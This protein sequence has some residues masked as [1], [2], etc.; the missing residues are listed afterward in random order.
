MHAAGLP[1]GDA[2]GDQIETRAML[3]RTTCALVLCQVVTHA[4]AQ[5]KVHAGTPIKVVGKQFDMQRDASLLQVAQTGTERLQLAEKLLAEGADA[6]LTDSYGYTPLHWAAVNGH[7][8]MTELLL[9]KTNADIDARN[10]RDLTPLF[11][12]AQNG[13]V[14][15][16]RVLLTHG[17]NPTGGG[18]SETHRMFDADGPLQVASRNGHQNIVNLYAELKLGEPSVKLNRV[19]GPPTQ[20]H[21]CNDRYTSHCSECSDD[22]VGVNLIHSLCAWME[23]G[24]ETLCEQINRASQCRR[25][26]NDPFVRDP[27]LVEF[28]AL[29]ANSESIGHCLVS[30]PH[31]TDDLAV[32]SPS[33]ERHQ[34]L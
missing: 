27:L 16:A 3:G 4:A 1:R 26:L 12:A 10:D 8:K 2:V 17:A 20:Y 25:F 18:L 6:T 15:V 23:Q 22:D 29:C 14:D 30:N 21:E 9:L 24:A 19:A 32:P 5:N 33:L 28:T 7:V 11:L 34:E 31:A 13:Q